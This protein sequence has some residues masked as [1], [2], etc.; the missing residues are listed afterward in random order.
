MSSENKNVLAEAYRW[1]DL[2][3][4]LNQYGD[5]LSQAG[6]DQVNFFGYASV[7][8][9][10]S[11]IKGKSQL[12]NER[13]VL[14]GS[15]VA[16][17]VYAA[18]DW[19]FSGTYNDEVGI[20]NTGLY[21][22]MEDALTDGGYA[23]GLNVTLEKSDFHS[24]MS[25]FATRELGDLPVEIDFNVLL[26]GGNNKPLTALKG[27]KKDDFGLYKLQLVM[28][29]AKDGR[30]VPA[31]T[32]AINEKSPLAAI[33]LTPVQAAHYIIDGQGYSRP[34]ANGETFLGGDALDYLD[35]V[36]KSYRDE[37]GNIV[38]HNKRVEAIKESVDKLI[39]EYSKM[40]DIFERANI[41]SGTQINTNN[42]GGLVDELSQLD[43]EFMQGISSRVF[44]DTSIFVDR[45]RVSDDIIHQ[46]NIPKTAFQKLERISQL[47]KSKTK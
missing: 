16:M 22:G 29:E 15:E 2:H 8:H 47:P 4:V 46:A 33:G 30:Q 5:L 11:D 14:H 37:E 25:A 21:A 3:K 24:G 28:T 44:Y 36:L 17:N 10:H 27:G 39:Q 19:E 1:S 34:S 13:V 45:T 31:L 12:P 42:A 7:I 18:G 40:H 23:D 38:Y 35:N 43:Q 20:H 9:N 26:N 32:A 6:K 41:T